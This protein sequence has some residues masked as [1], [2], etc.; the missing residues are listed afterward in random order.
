MK[1]I[2]VKTCWQ[3]WK[4][5]PG[6][7][8]A[9]AALYKWALVC[10]R[11]FFQKLLQTR[12]TCR[13]LTFLRL[14]ISIIT[15]VIILKRLLASGSV[16]I[17]EWS[18]RLRLGDYLVNKPLQATGMSADNVRGWEFVRK[19]NIWPRSEA[20]RANVKFCARS[21]SDGL[22]LRLPACVLLINIVPNNGKRLSLKGTRKKSVQPGTNW[23]LQCCD[24]IVFLPLTFLA[25]A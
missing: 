4:H 25:S 23:L 17:V 11:L 16:N 6:L 18:P 20:S 7:E 1:E 14:G 10:V 12:S 8:S 13:N 24:C 2:F 22:E 5:R 15:W 3:Y 9:H 21:L 19:M